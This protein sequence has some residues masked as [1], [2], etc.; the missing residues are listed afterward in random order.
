MSEN[1]SS[2]YKDEQEKNLKDCQLSKTDSQQCLHLQKVEYLQSED[3]QL[4]HESHISQSQELSKENIP[5]HQSESLVINTQSQI[6]Q[7]EKEKNSKEFNKQHQEADREKAQMIFSQIETREGNSTPNSPFNLFFAPEQFKINQEK[8]EALEKIEKN[9]VNY[10]GDFSPIAKIEDSRGDVTAQAFDL[11]MV[12]SKDLIQ[13]QRILSQGGTVK[14]LPTKSTFSNQIQLLQKNDIQNTKNAKQISSAA[15]LPQHI[16]QPISMT[17]LSANSKQ[18]Q[19][20]QKL[21]E[22]LEKYSHQMM[23]NIQLQNQQTDAAIKNNHT[24]SMLQ[25][26]NKNTNQ[27]QSEKKSIQAQQSQ[28][29][30]KFS[31]PS[32]KKDITNEIRQEEIVQQKESKEKSCTNNFNQVNFQNTKK[33]LESSKAERNTPNNQKKQAVV[34]NSNNCVKSMNRN[35]CQSIQESKF[36]HNL[37]SKQIFQ[38]LNAFGSV[39]AFQNLTQSKFLLN[40]PQKQKHNSNQVN[41]KKKQSYQGIKQEAQKIPQKG[42]SSMICDFNRL[43]KETYLSYSPSDKVKT[44]TEVL[45]RKSMLDCGQLQKQNQRKYSD[46]SSELHKRK[47]LSQG[48][49]YSEKIP[50]QNYDQV[51]LYNMNLNCLNEFDDQAN[52]PQQKSQ[53]TN[54]SNFT[55]QRINQN[56]QFSDLQEQN[57]LD[58]EAFTINIYKRQQDQIQQAGQNAQSNQTVDKECN[59]LN[60]SPQLQYLDYQKFLSKE[61]IEEISDSNNEIEDEENNVYNQRLIQRSYTQDNMMRNTYQLNSQQFEEQKIHQLYEMKNNSPSNTITIQYE[62]DKIQFSKEILS[63]NSFNQE[64]NK[65]FTNTQIDRN[66]EK[67]NSNKIA[68]LYHINNFQV[69]SESNFTAYTNAISTTTQGHKAVSSAKCIDQDEDEVIDQRLQSHT[70]HTLEEKQLDQQI[71]IIE[72]NVNQENPSNQKAVIPSKQETIQVS[73]QN[74]IQIIQIQQKAQSINLKSSQQNLVIQNKSQSQRQSDQ[75]DF[76]KKQDKGTKNINSN[77]NNL[78]KSNA[79]LYLFNLK[80]ESINKNTKNIQKKNQNITLNQNYFALQNEGNENTSKKMNQTQIK[81]IKH[82]SAQES[83]NKPSYNQNLSQ[84]NKYQQTIDQIVQNDQ[85][86]KLTPKQISLEKQYSNPKQQQSKPSVIQTNETQNNS[87]IQTQQSS[88]QNLNSLILDKHKFTSSP[89]TPQST[90][91]SSI[92]F[93]QQNCQYSQLFQQKQASKSSSFNELAQKKDKF[94]RNLNDFNSPQSINLNQKQKNEEISTKAN[95]KLER[96]F[97]TLIPELRIKSTK[98]KTQQLC[99][100]LSIIYEPNS[101]IQSQKQSKEVFEKKLSQKSQKYNEIQSTKSNS[102]LVIQ[103]KNQQKQTTAHESEQ[104][105]SLNSLVPSVRESFSKQHQIMLDKQ[106]KSPSVNFKQQEISKTDRDHLKNSEKDLPKQNVGRCS[107]QK[108]I[109]FSQQRLK[110]QPEQTQ[111]SQPQKK[112]SQPKTIQNFKS[113]AYQ[114]MLEKYG[115]EEYTQEDQQIIQHILSTI[116]NKKKKL[117]IETIYKDP[118]SRKKHEI[119]QL[120]E[121]TSSLPFFDGYIQAGQADIHVQCCKRMKLEVYQKGQTVFQIGEYGQKFYLILHGGVSVSIKM[122]GQQN[123]FTSKNEINVTDANLENMINEM[124]ASN[125]NSFSNNQHNSKSL[126]DSSIQQG[127]TP[128]NKQKPTQM[129]QVAVLK[130]GCQFGEMALLN[131]QPRLATIQCL[132]DCIFAIL[133]KKDFKDVLKKFEEEKLHKEMEYLSN[134]PYFVSW[135]INQLKNLFLNSRRK[136]YIKDQ[137]IF[138]EGDKLDAIYIIRKGYFE[139]SKLFLRKQNIDGLNLEAEEIQIFDENEHLNKYETFKKDMK[140]SILEEKTM[141]GEEDILQKNSK[142]TFSVK[143]T[144]LNGIAIRIEKNEFLYRVMLE[145]SSKIY[146]LKQL[147]IKENSL[148]QRIL[149]IK[150]RL[151]QFQNYF[152]QNSKHKEYL[153]SK[154]Q[155]Q[156]LKLFINH[157]QPQRNSQKQTQIEH[158]QGEESKHKQMTNSSVVSTS[159]FTTRTS[160][161]VQISSFADAFKLNTRQIQ[162]KRIN[163]SQSQ[164]SYLKLAAPNSENLENKN[165]IINQENKSQILNQKSAQFISHQTKSSSLQRTQSS[166]NLGTQVKQIKSNDI[167]L[168][169][170]IKQSL[171]NQKYRSV[172]NEEGI[173]QNKNEV[174]L[175]KRKQPL[176]ESQRPRLLYGNMEQTIKSNF[177]KV[178]QKMIRQKGSNTDVKEISTWNKVSLSFSNQVLVYNP[179]ETQNKLRSI[180]AQKR[181][182]YENLLEKAHQMVRDLKSIPDQEESQ[183]FQSNNINDKQNN[184]IAN[185]NLKQYITG[186]EEKRKLI[187]SSSSSKKLIKVMRNFQSSRQNKELSKLVD[188]SLENTDNQNNQESYLRSIDYNTLSKIYYTPKKISSAYKTILKIRKK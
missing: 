188:C 26:F 163:R 62:Q 165:L 60:N 91:N 131:N 31:S 75:I 90:Q 25:L 79:P 18:E 124:E 97:I 101:D 40:S 111:F 55:E 126:V 183:S 30:N 169:Q 84:K 92:Q 171:Q 151:T 22:R 154:I 74:K 80:K 96:Q 4:P 48:N 43:Q 51:Q 156:S 76:R 167:N 164:Q 115:Q 107:S 127:Q 178:F 69:S 177:K 2:T 179:T 157:L 28:Q 89:G 38:N 158:Q 56:T 141:V 176:E 1:K 140:I 14:A 135:N 83:P 88:Q 65:Y 34:F 3:R 68:S 70:H 132:E 11:S 170:I 155:S 16:N 136:E 19:K 64:E 78:N 117:A 166:T 41:G 6:D 161:P 47:S 174:A 72:K 77:N 63:E 50:L 42:Y 130:D 104:A 29:N 145:E 143:C 137:Y 113:Q 45:K 122:P 7:Q 20:A 139:Q 36:N 128:H 160:I 66:R 109:Q 102:S 33:K 119:Q 10:L 108:H 71:Q 24:K 58:G 138:Q 99:K 172:S 159:E 85:R 168:F 13:S 125:S 27:K 152:Y 5:V 110:T 57:D 118:S 116:T 105:S 67:L 8:L 93:Y 100:T 120:I 185:Q 180:S 121:S 184:N 86:G 150:F 103:S 146:L 9:L 95:S 106:Q 39:Q 44:D 37:L 61:Q 81:D 181:Q 82:F 187:R 94:I 186:Q 98:Q 73:T 17:K 148:Q 52:S 87:Q 59:T 147:E 144:S 12:Q 15:V 32:S 46:N 114:S 153:R 162:V 142:R 133:G 149:D 129:L 49:F 112:V 54:Q 23:S 182:D 21:R 175:V 53:I 134:L 173:H 123:I 35:V